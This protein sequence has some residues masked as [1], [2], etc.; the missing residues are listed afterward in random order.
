MPTL[1]AFK[2]LEFVGFEPLEDVNHFKELL[3]SNF[4][5]DNVFFI[6]SG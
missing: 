4:T 2:D 1:A 3:A 6:C 5:K